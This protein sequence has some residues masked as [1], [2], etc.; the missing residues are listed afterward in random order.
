MN[1]KSTFAAS[2][3][4]LFQVV[5]EGG[6]GQV[7]EG[8]VALW[9]LSLQQPVIVPCPGSAG[10]VIV[11]QCEWSLCLGLFRGSS[12]RQFAVCRHC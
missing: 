7:G 11:A 10:S 12:A 6:E 8:L 9:S 3:E 1:I 2:L 4:G 5:G